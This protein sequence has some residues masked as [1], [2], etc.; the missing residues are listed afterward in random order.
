MFAAKKNVNFFICFFATKGFP[1][2]R[3][4][5]AS[6]VQMPIGHHIRREEPNLRMG[7]QGD[8]LIN[9]SAQFSAVQPVRQKQET[10]LCW[11]S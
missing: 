1:R 3:R 5:A 7:G 6:Q 9:L 8:L 10:R 11:R 2:M 4:D